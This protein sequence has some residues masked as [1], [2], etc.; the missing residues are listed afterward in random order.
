[1][2]P[3]PKTKESKLPDLRAEIQVVQTPPTHDGVP[4]WTII[5]LVRNKFF[6]IGWTEYQLVSRWWCSTAERLIEKVNSETT[7]QVTMKDV[8]QLVK[9]LYAHSLTRDAATGGSKSFATQ[10]EAGGGNWA[11][12]VVHNY[13]FIR[14]PLVRPHRFLRATMPIVAPLFSRTAAVLVAVL[15]VIGL[16]LVGRQWESF[17]GT[18]LHFFNAKGLLFYGITLCFVKVLHELGHAYTATRFGCRVPTMGVALMVLFPVL[19]TDTSEAWRLRYRDQRLLIG[20]AG[21]ITE[22]GLA[23]VATFLWSF[24]P[25]GPFRSAAFILATTSWVLAI[26][27]NLNPMLRF[28]GYYILS[29]WLRVPNLQDRA[30]AIGRWRLR[31]LLFATVE[32][33]PEDISTSMRRKL[34]LYA[35]AVWVFRFFL[36]TG[37]AV[38]VYHFFFK[39]LGIILFAVE[40]LWFILLPIAREIALWWRM[41][42]SIARQSRAWLSAAVFCLV[43]LLAFVPWS[44]RVSIPAVLEAAEHATIYAPAPG[45][46]THVSV[47]EGQRVNPGDVLLV[48]EAPAIAKDLLLTAKRIAVLELH[49]LRRAAHDVELANS[50]VTEQELK[51]RLSELEG[52][53]EKRDNL[54]LTA[55]IHG[56]VTDIADSLHPGR[57]INGTLPLVYIVQRETAEVQALAPEE[58]LSRLAPGQTARFIPDD[59]NR[60]AREARIQEIRQVDEG[61]FSVPYLASTY[62]GAIA[63]RRD[64]EGRLEPEASVYRVRLPLLGNEPAPT[65]ALRGVIHVEGTPR[66]FAQR[67]RD[68]VAAVLI[69]ESGF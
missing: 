45:R 50:R 41:R 53:L 62:G 61:S 67:L 16:Y 10:A 28:D 43:V 18:F 9:F 8:H 35:W 23:L 20:A 39:L 32:D 3:D 33:P 60:P 5:D 47:V 51:T 57:W 46:I 29:D 2:R 63:V 19:Y 30:F 24:L 11:S 26:F 13:L 14:I 38:L 55:P 34:V 6:Q 56:V 68:V 52:L 37:I 54:V 36:F 69:R 12:W 48:L 7:C 4:T 66:S 22:L 1:M 31:Q 17:T 21:M 40:I 65:Q 25:Q 64:D 42:D 58:G 27:V 44:T 49:S 59:I 15:G